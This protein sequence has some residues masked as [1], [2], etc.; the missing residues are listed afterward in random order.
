[1]ARRTVTTLT[2]DLDGGEAS[3]TVTFGLDGQ[4]YEID[5]SAEN[6]SKF[7]SA[8]AHYVASGRKVPGRRSSAKAEPRA[9]KSEFTA[10]DTA[11]VRAWAA[12]NDIELSARGRIAARIIEQYRAA[13]N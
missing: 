4:T 2:D 7:R 8:L 11:A 13:G 10:V 1:M 5:L 3:E 12:A 9:S 6:S